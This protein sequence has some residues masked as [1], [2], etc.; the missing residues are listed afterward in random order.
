MADESETKLESFMKICYN[1]K[2]S[3]APELFSKNRTNKDGLASDC[4]M[5][6]KASSKAWREVNVDKHKANNRA[7]YLANKEK[8]LHK[9]KVRDRANP[10]KKAAKY[11]EWSQ[12]NPDKR[13][14]LN[15]KRRASELQRTPKWACFESIKKF[16]TCAKDLEE[17]TGISF[18]VDH[19]IPL[20]GEL[21][22][23]LHVETNLQ[24][25]TAFENSSKSN[26]YEVC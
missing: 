5:C 13:R 15:A 12:A 24:I 7:W 10:E 2:E 6:N 23:G 11:R 22:S 3:K 25:L 14:A 1:C 21:V 20:Q 17:L 9:Q 4:K 18:H 8:V 19:I 26:A 16:Y